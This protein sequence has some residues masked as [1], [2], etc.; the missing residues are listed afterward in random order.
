[1]DILDSLI[2]IEVLHESWPV[3]RNRMI[4][5]QHQTS[6]DHSTAR[7]QEVSGIVVWPAFTDD[8]PLMSKVSKEKWFQLASL[9]RKRN[10]LSQHISKPS[11]L[12]RLKE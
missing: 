6:E 12:G 9:T 1:M 10:L 7:L 11:R 3:T 8:E 4:L 2:P 5:G